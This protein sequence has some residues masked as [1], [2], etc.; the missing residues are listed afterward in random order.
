MYHVSQK[1]TIYRCI[2]DTKTVIYVTDFVVNTFGFLF[3][4]QLYIPND[5]QGLRYKFNAI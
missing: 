2:I 4:L 3:I 1:I 5:L